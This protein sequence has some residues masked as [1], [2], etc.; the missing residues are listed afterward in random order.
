[1][2][3]PLRALTCT[4]PAL[5]PKG[6]RDPITSTYKVGPGI[7]MYIHIY[8]HV[9]LSIMMY[10]F[11]Y[12]LPDDPL[13]ELTFFNTFEE[14]NLPIKGPMEDAIVT[15]SCTN[16]PQH[17]VCTWLQ[18]RW[19]EPPLCHC[20]WLE[21]RLRQSLT[22]TA[23]T[24]ILVSPWS[25]LTQHRWTAGVAAM[26]MRLTRGRGNLGVASHAWVICQLRQL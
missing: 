13:R 14:L 5:R 11:N 2:K 1:M 24:R 19:A 21:T 8:M 4:S 25:A 16:H 22:C 12:F 3:L 26:S 6:G 10:V 15:P 20:F 17:S 18:L 9:Y 7:Y 23:S